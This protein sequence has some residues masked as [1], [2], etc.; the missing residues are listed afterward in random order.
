MLT[1]LF[2]K[3]GISA[4]VE[5]A[6][7]CVVWGIEESEHD[8]ERWKRSFAAVILGDMFCLSD[9]ERISAPSTIVTHGINSIPSQSNE[10]PGSYH[11]YDSPSRSQIRIVPSSEPETMRLPSGENE[12]E[13]TPRVWSSMQPRE[14]FSPSYV[15]MQGFSLTICEL[16]VV[17]DVSL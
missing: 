12:T 9:P 15:K 17:F 11:L 8:S 16:L 7:R 2:Q 14:G 13:L 3:F 4:I 10:P 1:T 6:R 5:T